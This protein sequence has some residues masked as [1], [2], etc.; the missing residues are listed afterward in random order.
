MSVSKQIS[1]WGCWDAASCRWR[2]SPAPS[3]GLLPALF[4]HPQLLTSQFV[5]VPNVRKLHPLVTLV[6]SDCVVSE[7]EMVNELFISELS[8]CLLVGEECPAPSGPWSCVSVHV[9]FFPFVF[10]V[11]TRYAAFL[12]SIICAFLPFFVFVFPSCFIPFLPQG[13]CL[14]QLYI[15]KWGLLSWWWN[16]RF[17]QCCYSVHKHCYK[18]ASLTQFCNGSGSQP[19]WKLAALPQHSL[20]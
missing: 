15:K 9:F 17:I 3:S 20:I 10:L 12:S 13:P 1:D 16:C 2:Q 14:L 5:P 19:L 7:W 18:C 6:T 11:L 8:G 4:L